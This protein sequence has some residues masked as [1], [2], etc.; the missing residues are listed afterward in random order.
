MQRVAGMPVAADAD[1][2][3]TG[4]MV[5]GLLDR[6]RLP[7]Y[8]WLSD[9]L[10]EARDRAY[11]GS[12]WE[13]ILGEKMP[14]G[15]VL[16]AEVAFAA[17][18]NAELFPLDMLA[19]D[20]IVNSGSEGCTLGWPIQLETF[21]VPWEMASPVEIV[22]AAVPVVAAVH[23]A[24]LFDESVVYHNMSVSCDINQ[25]FEDWLREWW[26][27]HGYE[28]EPV[29]TWPRERDRAMELLRGLPPPLDGLAGVYAGVV[30]GAGNVFFDWPGGYYQAEYTNFDYFCWCEGCVEDLAGQFA[31][32]RDDVLRMLAY[33]R[34]FLWPGSSRQVTEALV[35]LEEGNGG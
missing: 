18:V 29:L 19:M 13:G 7:S 11:V 28:T 26:V 20:D 32:V 1:R 14:D 25:K 5:L 8:A 2:V 17:R 30:K 21:G 34:W 23:A 33:Q 10:A 3:L 31:V 9:W 16:D 4:A 6:F 22:D 12:L 24:G 27:G 35:G 15:Y